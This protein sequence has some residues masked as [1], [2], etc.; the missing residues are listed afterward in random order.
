MAK[1]KHP[2]LNL[3]RILDDTIELINL[4]RK[5]IEFTLFDAIVIAGPFSMSEW[6]GFLHI[7]ERTL[8]RYRQDRRLFEPMQLERILE[9]V[10][11]QKKGMEVF[12]N[13]EALDLWLNSPSVAFGG[14]KPKELLDNTFGIQLLTDELIRIEHGVLA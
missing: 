2:K 8:Q 4:T 13:L 10:N 3:S 5:G 12:G 6:G 9:I 7:S 14:I 1:R 11:V